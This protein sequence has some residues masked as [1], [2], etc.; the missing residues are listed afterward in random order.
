MQLKR[1]MKTFE[2]ADTYQDLSIA[3]HPSVAVARLRGENRAPL[4][5][6]WGR[7]FIFLEFWIWR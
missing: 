5:S 3:S 4:H 6:I 1:K 2:I 7:K